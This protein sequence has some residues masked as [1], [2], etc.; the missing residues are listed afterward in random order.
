MNKLVSKFLDKLYKQIPNNKWIN[1]PF[2][3]L[4]N[5]GGYGNRGDI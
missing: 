3:R 4:N 5:S 2:I 1:S